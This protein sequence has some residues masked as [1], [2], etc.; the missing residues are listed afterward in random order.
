MNGA[1]TGTLLIVVGALLVV[2]GIAVASGVLD[3]FGHLP[4]DI[5]IERGS[6]RIYFPL[7]SMLVA[8]VVVS[9]VFH[10]LRRF[11]G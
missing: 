10:L 8:S 4:G 2:A 1:S 5:R 11:L 7:T 3:W 9:V 6:T